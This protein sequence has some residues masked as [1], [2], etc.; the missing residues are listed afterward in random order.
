MADITDFQ[1]GQGESFRAYMQLLDQGHNN[2]PVDITN[3]V[4][5]GHIRENYTTDELAAQFSFEKVQPYASGAVYIMLSPEITNTLTQ[6]KYVYDIKFTS[7]SLAPVSRR[8]LE[9]AFTVR[10]SVTR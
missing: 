1:I 5:D 6:R 4:F 2:V 10:P 9:G 8:L 3:Y 7:G